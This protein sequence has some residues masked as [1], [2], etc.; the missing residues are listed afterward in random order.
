[1]LPIVEL[2]S[3]VQGEGQFSGIPSHFIRVTG[4][5]LRCVFKD[6]IC[7]TAYTSFKPEQPLY[8]ST[9]EFYAAFEE[10]CKKYPN[11]HH[12]VI[13]GGEPLLYRKDLENFL[14]FVYQTGN[15]FTVTI[16][17]NGTQKPL[18][19]YIDLYS[20]SPKLSTSVGKPGT[21]RC[22]G[23]EIKITEDMVR[24]QEFLRI[25]IPAL[26]ELITTPQAMDYQLKFVYSGESCI[27]EIEDIIQ[28]IKDYS[29]NLDELSQGIV[30]DVDNHIMLMPEGIVN[31][32]LAVHRKE[33]AE[34]CI[35]K[36][37]TMT[38]REHII[39]WGNK[40]CV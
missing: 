29:K 34:K 16:E 27:S 9:E 26:S 23:R 40:R 14:D 20:I 39:I 19:S 35:E 8:K 10:Q 24:K 3:T 12:I 22:D 21:I 1:M 2:F 30:M 7:D 11:V 4:C 31:E 32:Q 17:T 18:D 33:I 5:N 6:S 37:W 25:N 28:R 38:D 15:S 36:G 13:T